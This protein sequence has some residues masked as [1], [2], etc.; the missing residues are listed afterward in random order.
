MR[1]EDREQLKGKNKRQRKNG[2]SDCGNGNEGKRRKYNSTE[3]CPHTFSS[4]VNNVVY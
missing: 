3:N 4:A 1:G 2:I